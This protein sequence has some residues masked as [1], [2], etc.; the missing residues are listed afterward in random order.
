MTEPDQFDRD[1]NYSQ[2]EDEI[3]QD[4][5]PESEE[6]GMSPN[7]RHRQDKIGSDNEE[8]YI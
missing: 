5:E 2:D 1:D 8:Q 3:E 6:A 7:K 4:F